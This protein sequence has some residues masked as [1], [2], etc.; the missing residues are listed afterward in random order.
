[1]LLLLVISQSEDLPQFFIQ[2]YVSHPINVNTASI[3]EL[4]QIPFLSTEDIEKI[5]KYRPFRGYGEFRRVLNMSYREFLLIRPYIIIP[6][7]TYEGYVSIYGGLQFLSTTNRNLNNNSVFD[8]IL[9][10]V[11][12]YEF[13]IQA[14]YRGYAF[15]IKDYN[16]TDTTIIGSDTILNYYNRFRFIFNVF[17]NN[18]AFRIGNFGPRIGYGSI[19]YRPRYYFLFYPSF[20]FPVS[21]LSAEFRYKNVGLFLDTTENAFLYGNYRNLYMGLI[22]ANYISIWSFLEINPIGKFYLTLEGSYGQNGYSYGYSLSY[23]DRGL[24]VFFNQNI[25][26][27]ERLWK[28][29]YWSDSSFLYVYM[30]FFPVDLRMNMRGDRG[31]I[32]INYEISTSSYAILRHY[33][34]PFFN[35]YQLSFSQT[36]GIFLSAEKIKNGGIL[37]VGYNLQLGR[38]YED[39]Y[40]KLRI[41]YY[42]T[43]MVDKN[44]FLNDSNLYYQPFDPESYLNVFYWSAYEGFFPSIDSR[45]QLYGTGT[46]FSLSV[47]Y[48]RFY[49]RFIDAGRYDF[50]IERSL[51]F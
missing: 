44:C 24:F 5:V 41:Y 38:K 6:T 27:G 35:S 18:F 45:I 21:N 42:N 12:D 49:F 26:K 50:G 51:F 11:N 32:T 28:Y 30:S 47:R 36:R 22:R 4:K 7:K 19:S 2:Q 37:T 10:K 46:K 34:H 20:N 3:E 31:S 1:M 40:I 14:Y 8:T 25:F 43:C 13:D 23:R 15:R 48:K 29:N 9:N 16:F 33:R 39:P 17:S